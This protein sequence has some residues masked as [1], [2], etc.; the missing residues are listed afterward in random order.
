MIPCFSMQRTQ[1]IL[2]LILE[3]QKRIKEE[4]SKLEREIVKSETEANNSRT[5]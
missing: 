1:E 2:V 4:I 5:S 3:E